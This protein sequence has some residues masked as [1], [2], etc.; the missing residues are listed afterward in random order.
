MEIVRDWRG[1]AEGLRGAVVALGNF[2]GV[3]LGH[4]HLLRTAHAARPGSTL[5]VLTFEPHPREFFR[6][7]D[8]PFRL[9]LA[10]ERAS[11]LAAL[12]VQRLYELPF[13]AALSALTAEAFVDAVLHEGIGAAHLACGA[14][15][16]FGHRRGGDAATLAA[17]GGDA[18]RGRDRRAE[19]FGRAGADQLDP[20]PAAAAGR[21]SRAGRDGTGAALG[22]ARPGDARRQAGPDDR[23]PHGQRAAGPASGAPRGGCM[24]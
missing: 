8:P 10:A 12:G 19:A 5:A 15:F 7:E 18:G 21:L 2:D 9:T 17:R 23:V 4:A 1:L 22:G 20:H 16:A 11:A 24:P 13:D 14:D 3:H 6:P